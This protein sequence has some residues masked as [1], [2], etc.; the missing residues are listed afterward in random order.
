MIWSNS[1]V[2]AWPQRIGITGVAEVLISHGA[3]IDIACEDETPLLKVTKQ[4][5]EPVCGAPVAVVIEG[6]GSPSVPK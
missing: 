2:P 4:K 6:I 5:R 1:F 3:M